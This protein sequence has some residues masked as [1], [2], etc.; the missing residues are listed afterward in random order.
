MYKS[1][2]A[3]YCQPSIPVETEEFILRVLRQE[4]D[5]IQ[6]HFCLGLVNWQGKNDKKRAV[7]DFKAFIDAGGSE[8]FA[9][10]CSLARAYIATLEGELRKEETIEGEPR[11]EVGR[12]SDLQG[13]LPSR[14]A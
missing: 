3:H 8:R 14:T 11:K 13:G 6:L 12:S 7:G 4:P 10:E 9:D 2:C 1:A 5:K